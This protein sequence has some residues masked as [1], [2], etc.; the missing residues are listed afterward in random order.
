MNHPMR[1][2]RASTTHVCAQWRQSLEVDRNYLERSYHSLPIQQTE[3]GRWLRL[4]EFLHRVP[5]EHLAIFITAD[6]DEIRMAY[7]NYIG[8][9]DK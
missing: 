5:Q 7:A 4:A 8:C 1:H 9:Y 2:Q 6:L 3:F